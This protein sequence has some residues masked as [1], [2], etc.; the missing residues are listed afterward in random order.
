[1]VFAVVYANGAELRARFQLGAPKKPLDALLVRQW[2]ALKLHDRLLAPAAT[3]LDH[4]K[5]KCSGMKS[6]RAIE[7]VLLEQAIEL[8][9]E[10]GKNDWEVELYFGAAC[11][12]DFMRVCG[13]Q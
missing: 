5:R 3:K 13:V 11:S 9:T 1:L 6:R 4:M 7:Q 8:E 12:D 10:R 2:G